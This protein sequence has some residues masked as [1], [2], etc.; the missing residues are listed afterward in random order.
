MIDE[1]L[2]L[3]LEAGESVFILFVFL[4]LI[5]GVSQGMVKCSQTPQRIPAGGKAK[6][7]S[8]DAS[9]G[10]KNGDH[11]S[12]KQEFDGAHGEGVTVFQ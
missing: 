11:E 2:H 9:Y 8:D 1:D 5:Q 7:K 4:A 3:T 12:S 10:S 6:Q